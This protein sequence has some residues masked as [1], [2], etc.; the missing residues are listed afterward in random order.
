VIRYL[1]GAHNEGVAAAA[2]A[3]NIGLLVQPGNR[4]DKQ[5]HRYP[6]WAADNGAF[7][8]K[9]GGFNAASF[10]TMLARPALLAARERC[11]FVVAPD[12]LVV[13]PC[14]TV[15]GDAAGT[16][17]QFPAWAAEIRALGY[18]VALVAQNG[19]E[20]MLDAVPWDL[21]DV[22]F[23]GG[24]TEWKIGPCAAA[25]T[26]HALALGKRVHMGRVNSGK[27]L[28]IAQ[29]MG[30]DTA[31]GTYLVFGPDKNLPKLLS[32]LDDAA[33]RVANDNAAIERLYHESVSSG[34][35]QR[36]F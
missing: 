5:I 6:D 29:A 23:I 33:E 35:H 30:C 19:L 8:T 36:A 9:K 20:G 13:L 17:E 15:V 14:G 32:W 28:A 7:T 12:K 2:H 10:R 18:P 31:D 25:C 16:L 24:S 1:T 11:L 21:V 3:Y 34:S 4:Y 22:L 26:A 27:R